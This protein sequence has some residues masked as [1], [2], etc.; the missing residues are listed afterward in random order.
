MESQAAKE[1]QSAEHHVFNVLLCLRRQTLVNGHCLALPG[2][3]DLAA[4]WF[5]V[6]GAIMSM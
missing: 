5:G 1:N 4:K 2:S 3:S 6:M